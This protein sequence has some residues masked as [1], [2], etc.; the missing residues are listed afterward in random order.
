MRAQTISLSGRRKKKLERQVEK[1]LSALQTH[2]NDH[3]IHIDLGDTYAELENID[4]GVKSYHAAIELL[5]QASNVGKTK[6]LIIGLYEKIINMTP[7]VYR[8]YIDLSEEYIAA[9]QKEKAFRFLLTSAK[10]A[11]EEENYELALECYNQ[12]IAK[13]R[14]NPHIVE[15]CTEL[16]MKLGRKQEAMQNYLQIGDMYAQEE[17]NIE[18][19]EYYKKACSVEPDNPELLLK[20]ARMYNAMAWTENAASELVKVGEHYEHNHDFTEALRYYNYSVR[21]DP[22]NERAQE[23]RTRINQSTTIDETGIMEAVA[24]IPATPSEADILEQLDQIDA[25]VE[26]TPEPPTTAD[27]E[28]T[29]LD[30]TLVFKGGGPDTGLLTDADTAEM[31][32]IVLDGAPETSPEDTSMQMNAESNDLNGFILDETLIIDSR[33]ASSDIPEETLWFSRDNGETA[34]GSGSAELLSQ[35]A[36]ENGLLN[37]ASDGQPST[38]LF[39]LDDQDDA[40]LPGPGLFSLTDTGDMLEPQDLSSI[41]SFAEPSESATPARIEP[42]IVPTS[43]AEEPFDSLRPLT[44]EE[45]DD[46]LIETG[47]LLMREDRDSDYSE[48]VSSFDEDLSPA[49]GDANV[50]PPAAEAVDT[51]VGTESSAASI[52]LEDWI[53]DLKEDELVELALEEALREEEHEASANWEELLGLTPSQPPESLPNGP[54][55]SIAEQLPAS[56]GST[57]SNAAAQSD[58]QNEPG[59]LIDI[60]PE[61][62]TNDHLEFSQKRAVDIDPNA[63]LEFVHDRTINAPEEV[64]DGET[65]EEVPQEFVVGEE[66]DV[67]PDTLWLEGDPEVALDMYLDDVPFDEAPADEMDDHDVQDLIAYPD[68]EE[69]ADVVSEEEHAD[70]TQFVLEVNMDGEELEDVGHNNNGVGT[71]L[72]DN[73]EPEKIESAVHDTLDM[74]MFLNDA[75]ASE[76]DDKI[77]VSLVENAD[78]VPLDEELHAN[79]IIADTDAEELLQTEQ[80][81]G[82]DADVSQTLD[83]TMHAE[84]HEA[85]GDLIEDNIVED[86]VGDAFPQSE[87]AADMEGLLE[88]ST[89]NAILAEHEPQSMTDVSGYSGDIQNLHQRINGLEQQ[90][91]RTEEEKYFLQERFA[92]QISQHKEHEESLQREIA[93]VYRDKAELE[94][95]LHVPGDETVAETSE[96]TASVASV[97]SGAS[98]AGFN[99]DR[100][101]ALI[102]KIEQKKIRVQKQ[103]RKLLKKREE[104]GRYLSQELD[105]L[106]TAKQ[107]LQQ[108]LEYIQQVKARVEEKV[109]TELR[110]SQKS[111]AALTKTSKSLESQL[112]A[113]R[114]QEQKLRKEFAVLRQEKEQLQADYA[115]TLSEIQH[116]KTELE[117]QVQ[118]VSHAKQTVE[119]TLKK[120]L[121]SLHRSY[122]QLKG[123]YKTVIELKDAQ[124]AE[125]AQ[126]LSDAT[127]K[128][129]KLEKIL[130]EIRKERARLNT[131]LHEEMTARESLEEK[132]VTIEAHVDSLDVQELKLVKRLD[133]ELEQYFSQ[134]QHVSDKFHLSLDEFEGLLALQEREI[135]TLEAI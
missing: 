108:N 53:I 58:N 96:T 102:G 126:Q 98:V 48:D 27:F 103:L 134:E 109:N 7:E 128:Y 25:T 89:M 52:S 45:G 70:H 67:V 135:Q 107:R 77:G 26:Y 30:A 75:E 62:R 8:P 100:Y 94:K 14:T 9:G 123:E 44:S 132:L 84:A 86:V 55:L 121:H 124:L 61:M 115:D 133:H 46:L 88:E 87:E 97:T 68:D 78:D 3:K 76:A 11:Y 59:D 113:Q 40:D 130:A 10:K 105:V 47:T 2:R 91:G 92:A 37:S 34:I 16:Y 104:G 13:G 106:T 85:A 41:F 23:G 28:L 63:T 80:M 19:L 72:H 35:H 71:F 125:S 112:R 129:K 120:K 56:D 118:Q 12:A 51:A 20:V 18:A 79:E 33:Q 93:D 42:G 131:R 122:K 21:L 74:G 99:N 111:V 127:G 49:G 114:Q 57:V 81:T 65:S 4:K 39:M 116:E 54:Q 43:D 38:N 6:N 117:Q 36:G 1:Y 50:L 29:P 32:T 22:E 17:K 90:L 95:Q 73:A 5:R 64:D 24:E 82:D 15:R 119:R 101:D 110:Q 66:S 83:E 31:E 60:Q 69:S